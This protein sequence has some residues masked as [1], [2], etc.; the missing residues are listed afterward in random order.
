M[1]LALFGPTASGKTT[2]AAALLERL[3]AEVVSADSAALYAD[4]PVITAAPDYPARL[5]GVFPLEHEVSVG[6]YQHLAHDA[7]DEVLG[8]ARIPILVGGTGLYFRAALG[9]LEIP[10]PPAPG[11]RER[12]SQAYD[13]LGPEAAHELLA[14][15]DPDAAARV[16]PNDRR[17]V[18]RALEL[19]EAGASLAGDELWAGELRRPGIVF[20][21]T[22]DP[23]RLENRIRARAKRMLAEG[24]A[25]EA[26]RAWSRP[27]SPT[28][29]KVLGLEEFATLPAD[30]AVE[31]VVSATRRLAR[32]QRKWIRRFPGVVTLDGDRSPEDIA[33]EIVALA[34]ARERLPRR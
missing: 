21:L 30:E 3:D 20:S 28:A 32:Y 34:G 9:S 25:E 13:E 4:L 33:D 19:A 23:A 27:L 10:P 14:R 15:N 1:I 24:A 22:V 29:R 7:I 11:V 6:E 26:A 17:R 12:W 5:V 16:H 2:L 18:V 8:A 31:A